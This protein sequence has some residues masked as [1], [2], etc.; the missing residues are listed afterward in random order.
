M[1]DTRSSGSHEHYQ[2][3]SCKLRIC[4]PPP[5][6]T[7][8]SYDPVEPSGEHEYNTIVNYTCDFGYHRLS[9]DPVRTCDDNKQWTGTTPSYITYTPDTATYDFNTTVS[10]A[11]ILGYNHT[12]G[13][14]TRTCLNTFDF[15]GMP[16]IC[17]IVECVAPDPIS[18]TIIANAVPSTYVY[19]DQISYACVIGYELT[20]GDSVRTCTE[21]SFWSGAPPNCT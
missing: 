3:H 18:Y 13:D 21:T 16:M 1:P 20:S 2:C 7:F 9:G 19:L 15:D 6:I 5:T 10:G 11:C 4:T 12:A 17:I 8:G 14:A